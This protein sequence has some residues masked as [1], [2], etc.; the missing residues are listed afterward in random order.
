MV[1][2]IEWSH[3]LEVGID[4]ID[5]QHQKLVSI[6]NSLYRSIQES[7]TQNRAPQP[8]LDEL[9][10]ELKDYTVYHFTSEENLM[11]TTG[12]EFAL[13]HIQEHQA[14]IRM[15]DLFM[16]DKETR[17]EDVLEALKRWLLV[18]I[19]GSDMVLAESMRPHLRA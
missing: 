17:A 8:A 1:C 5:S 19:A 4:E 10:V 11:N 12:Y 7:G 15:I 18:H 6:L 9:L 2:L 3:A 14:F 13:H 16:A